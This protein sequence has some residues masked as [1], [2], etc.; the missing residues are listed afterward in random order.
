[1]ISKEIVLRNLKQ[2][3]PLTVI[4]LSIITF[5]IYFIY[6]QYCFFEEQRS[7]RKQGWSGGIYLLFTFIVPIS[8]FVWPFL[9]PS[10]VG[11]LYEEDNQEKPIT[12]LT[13]FWV[14][15][16]IFGPFII[17]YK[18]QNNMNNF[19]ESKIQIE[20]TNAKKIEMLEE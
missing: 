6:W 16:P 12:G 18:I 14:L 20:S 3:D 10:Y 4:I 11:K 13:G 15:L 8:G 19:I 9:T 2:R 1:M 17:V 5:G 7:I